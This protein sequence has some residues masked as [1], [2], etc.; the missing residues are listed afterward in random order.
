MIFLDIDNSILLTLLFFIDPGNE[1]VTVF[2]SHQPFPALRALSQCNASAL[3]F[4][5]I[6]FIVCFFLLCLRIQVLFTFEKEVQ[7]VSAAA[8][9]YSYTNV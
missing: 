7:S 6:L 3:H 4:A 1:V 5:L 9:A 8:A 2:I